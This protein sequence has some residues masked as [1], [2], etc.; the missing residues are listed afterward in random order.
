MEV[1]H[2]ELTLGLFVQL[3]GAM[4]QSAFLRRFRE[5]VLIAMG[6]LETAELAARCGSTTEVRISSPMAYDRER[7]HPLAGQVFRLPLQSSQRGSLVIGRE[8]PTHVVVPDETVSAR[9]CAVTWEGLDVQVVDLGSTNGTLVNLHPFDPDR[10]IRLVDDDFITVG[11]HSFQFFRPL[12]LYRV[13]RG[14]TGEDDPL[15]GL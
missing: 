9:H 3:A 7:R 14:L 8:P 4:D 2:S 5:P 12:N 13:L 6:V 11:R 1:E 10:P 15:D